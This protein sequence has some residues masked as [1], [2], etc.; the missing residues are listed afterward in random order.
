VIATVA[1]DV[2][3]DTLSLTETAGVGTL[4]LGAVQSDG[5]QQV[6]Y[7]APA[8]ISQSVMDAVTYTVN[9]SDGASVWVRRP[10]ARLWSLLRQAVAGRLD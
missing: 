10:T 7:T 9:E 5:T 6:I 4:S 1:P 3:G 2:P 8:S